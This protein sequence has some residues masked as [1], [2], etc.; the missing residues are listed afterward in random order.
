MKQ[1]S[2][3]NRRNRAQERSKLD[4]IQIR[5]A[6]E[7]D[8]AAIAEIYNQGVDD[9]VATYETKVRSVEDQRTWIHSIAGRYPIIV[10]HIDGEIIGWAGAA[11]YRERECYRGIG[12]LS[13]YVHRD[14]RAR[15]VGD[16]LLAALINEAERLRLWK[17][18]ARVFLFN[19]ASRALCRKHG[20]REVGVYEK[21]ARLD[22]RWLDVV[23]VER[24]I[25]SNV[26]A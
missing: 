20:F 11:A 14:W 4:R 17:L 3:R 5:T 8:A 16:K 26:K 24:L 10:A 6:T 21:H 15:G 1:P 7:D 2:Q 13:M 22:G 25:P 12:E 19:E 18:L 9:R 23:I